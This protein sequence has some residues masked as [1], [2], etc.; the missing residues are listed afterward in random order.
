MRFSSKN[1][2]MYNFFQAKSVAI[3]GAS[4]NPKKLGYQITANLKNGGF[5]GK[6]FPINLDEAKILGLPVHQTVLDIHRAIDLATI[7]VPREVVPMVLKQCVLKEIPNVLIITA[8]FAEKDDK[9]KK[10]QREIIEITQRSKTRIIG[11]NCL[12]IINTAIGL[13]LTFAATNVAKGNI[14][15]ILQSGAIGAAILDWA[16]ENEIGISKFVSLGN[17]VQISELEALKILGSDPQTKVIALYLEEITEPRKFLEVAK[18]TTRNKPVIILKGGE[19]KQGS[20][21]ARSHTAALAS[22]EELDTALFNQAN[23][24]I[25]HT[26]EDLL[27]LLELC[28]AKNF[29]VTKKN[30]AIVTNAGGPGILAADAASRNKMA[31]VRLNKSIKSK[32]ER[33]LDSFASLENP[34]DLG[35]DASALRFEK[36]IE[37]LEKVP[38]LDSIIIIITP[39]AVT[40]LEKTAKVISKFRSSSKPIV[41]TFLGGQKIKKAVRLLSKAHVPH[42]ED[43]SMAIEQLS[44]IY[45]YF[46]KKDK[47]DHPIELATKLHRSNT[48][49]EIIASYKIPFVKTIYVNNSAE[50]MA[51]VEEIGFPL[52]YKTAKDIKSKQKSGKVGLNIAE[53]VSLHRSTNAIGYPGIIQPM[54]DSIYEIMV[55]AK[56]DDHFGIVLVFGR[57]GIF[58]EEKKDVS[59]KILPLTANDLE[60]MIEETEIFSAISD[61]NVK[62]K[63]KEAIINVAAIMVDNPD[64][65][66]I[67]FNPFKVEQNKITAVDINIVRK[68]NE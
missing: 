49:E 4:A 63:I 60:E 33:N 42:F 15:L 14:G 65:R 2:I 50:T 18:M 24:I 58:I 28:S 52:I 66:E 39:Q 27:N 54:I 3:I 25:A 5:E 8:G 40:E 67:E 21:A 35:G 12:G 47:I 6:I 46:H 51:A 31:L 10:L 32:L 13:N 34:F 68:N 56:R 53:N 48:P 62:D 23:L 17:K 45:K 57:G 9:G 26:Y 38:D 36:M 55:G 16:K 64:I 37:I 43:P 44:I 59:F 20:L 61:F 41:A 30:L 29:S 22:S 7:I 19:T 11:P 1:N